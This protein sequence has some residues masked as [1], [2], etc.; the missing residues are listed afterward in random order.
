MSIKLDP[1]TTDR[2]RKVQSAIWGQHTL[3]GHHEATPSIRINWIGITAETEMFRRVEAGERFNTTGLER[4]QLGRVTRYDAQA[5]Y[6]AREGPKID[7]A[8]RHEDKQVRYEALDKRP[9][10]DMASG[11]PAIDLPRSPQILMQINPIL[12]ARLLPG[13]V[14]ERP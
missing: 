14:E 7:K 3:Q 13:F 10:I 2:Y 8:N 6:L 4:G 5:S 1:F 11:A 9:D 12:Y